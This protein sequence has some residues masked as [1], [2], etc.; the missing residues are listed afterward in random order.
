MAEQSS[1]MRSAK[2]LLVAGAALFLVGLLQGAVVQSFANP[3]M[4][5]SAHLTAVQS[6]M[7][8]MIVGLAWRFI[9]LPGVVSAIA[10]WTIVLGMYGLWAALT[11]SAATGASRSLPMAGSGFQADRATELAVT[12]AIYTSSA[13]MTVGWLL[14]VAGLVRART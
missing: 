6:G 7:A 11:A 9:R 2:F 12:V 14:F 8:I 5:L 3:R 13:A 4:A 1:S 10:R